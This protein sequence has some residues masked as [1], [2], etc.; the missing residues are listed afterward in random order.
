MERRQSCRWLAAFGLSA[1]LAGSALAGPAVEVFTTAGE[2]AVNVPL[3]VAVIELDAPGRLDAEL[4]Q[5]LPA[6]LEVAEGLMRERMSVPEWQET[7][8]RYADSYLGL[9]RAWQLG[10]EKVPA[11]VVDG[12]H[13]IYGQPD[14]AAALREAERLLGQEGQR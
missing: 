7:A 1:C 12:R 5:D 4:S 3:G 6:D 10:I 8:D 11:V 9:V 14:V 13:V 2:P